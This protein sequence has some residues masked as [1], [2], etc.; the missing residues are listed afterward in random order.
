MMKNESE[1][2]GYRHITL[3]SGAGHDAQ[4]VASVAEPGMIFIPCEDGISHS[5]KEKIRWEDLDKG[6]NLLLQMLMKLAK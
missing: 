1:K 4:I 6:A 2:L 5:P 3:P